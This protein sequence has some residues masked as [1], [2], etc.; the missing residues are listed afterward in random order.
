M[1]LLDLWSVARPGP[2]RQWRRRLI[3]VTYSYTELQI[4]GA[5]SVLSCPLME[6][7]W[8]ASP[9][10]TTTVDT[11]RQASTSLPNQLNPLPLIDVP[12]KKS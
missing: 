2:E 3:R 7:T 1:R 6:R 11:Y 8:E 5:V 12:D 4:L 10:A 9:K